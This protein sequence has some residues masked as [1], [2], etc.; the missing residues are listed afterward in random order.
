MLFPSSCAV[1]DAAGP[2][3]CTTCWSRLRRAPDLA[4]PDGLDQVW[5]LLA[6]DGAARAL[7][8]GLKYRNARS[9]L[10]RLG[11]ALARLISTQPPGDDP[12]S[13]F[14]VVTWAPTSPARRRERGFDQAQ[15]L[16]HAVARDLGRPCRPLLVRA[17]GRPQTGRSRDE[18][19]IGP[20]FGVRNRTPG[21]V[22]VVDD[23]LTTGATLRAAA[24]ALREA[25]SEVV[26]G[27]TAAHTIRH[28]GEPVIVL[29]REK[30]ERAP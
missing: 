10:G 11:A 22:L 17:P 19:L 16:A 18:R 14:D 20:S 6:Y 23:V 2:V 4:P 3:L 13:P 27:A 15:L 30:I 9:I 25:G 28:T 7:I 21:R 8:V 1:C 24:H 29:A 5:S 26:S 12:A